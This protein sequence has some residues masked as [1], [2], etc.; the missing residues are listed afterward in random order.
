MTKKIKRRGDK[1]KTDRF[2]IL[3]KKILVTDKRKTSRN[4]ELIETD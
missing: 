3:V 1:T 2:Y 4:K